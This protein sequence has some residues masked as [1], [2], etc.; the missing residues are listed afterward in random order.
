LHDKPFW[1]WSVED[2]KQED[3]RTD[4]DCC[5]NHIIGVPQKDGV[6]KPL[7]DYEEIIFDC[8]AAENGSTKKKLLWIKKATGLGVS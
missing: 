4:D 8:L 1:I 2:H 5:M 6:D 7:F 3:I